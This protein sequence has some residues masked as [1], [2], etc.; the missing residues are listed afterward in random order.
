MKFETGKTYIFWGDTKVT[1]VR[2]TEKSVWLKI[3]LGSWPV[4][5]SIMKHNPELKTGLVPKR[6][7]TNFE[8]NES[9]KLLGQY[10]LACSCT[11]E[12][13]VELQGVEEEAK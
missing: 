5:Q 1:V 9:F 10:G 13:D 7:W 2:R 12:Y 3:D 8:G 6:V 11:G 4:R